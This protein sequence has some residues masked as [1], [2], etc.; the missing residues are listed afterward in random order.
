[1][2]TVII[3]KKKKTFVII[4]YE[5][6]GKYKEINP[7]NYNMILIKKKTPFKIN[8][9]ATCNTSTNFYEPHNTLPMLIYVSRIHEFI[10][11]I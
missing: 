1:M 11:V 7:R 5:Y 3:L 9:N 6:R 10:K 8:Y 2:L 4:L